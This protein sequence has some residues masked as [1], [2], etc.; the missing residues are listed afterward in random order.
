MIDPIDS[1]SPTGAERRDEILLLARGAARQ[2]RLRRRASRAIVVGLAMLLIAAGF[3]AQIVRVS[4][5]EALREI[6]KAP[7][8]LPAVPKSA[9]PSAPA[10]AEITIVSIETDPTITS[11]LSVGHPRPQWKSIGDDELLQSLADAGK[12]SGII[13]TDG[14]KILLSR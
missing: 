1:L 4:H 11:R 12:P 7:A 5:R 10:S 9:T 8:P 6:V 3:M 2:Q 13:E 14:R